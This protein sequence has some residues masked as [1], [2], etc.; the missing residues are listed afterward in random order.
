MKMCK[1]C[2]Q[3]KPFSEMKKDKRYED[4]HAP[5]CKK[6]H[7][8]PRR[9]MRATEKDKSSW[10]EGHR[11]CRKCD[12]MLPLG[13]FGNNKTMP[14]GV[15]SICKQCRK[16]MSKAYY[17]KWMVGNPAKRMLC[18]A[19]ARAANKNL[20]FSITEKDIVVPEYCPVLGIKITDLGGRQKDSSPSLDRLIPSLG[21]TPE[22]IRVISWR[23]NWIKQNSTVD[24]IQK[25]ALWMK[26][27]S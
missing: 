5:L 24:E 1:R 21:Y 6:C 10:P 2:E 3:E 9:N 27:N 16:P 22:N 25:L 7:G 26:K 8:L 23:A 11:P 19:R 20:P 12:Q 18:S 13:K 14:L 4:G 17:N 15:H